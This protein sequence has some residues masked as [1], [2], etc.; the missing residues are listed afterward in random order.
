METMYDLKPK[1]ETFTYGA[2][3]VKDIG[4]EVQYEISRLGL[5]EHYIVLGGAPMDM[6]AKCGVLF[7]A[8]S[9]V[10]KVPSHNVVCWNALIS[11]YAQNR[12]GQQALNPL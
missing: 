9:V 12:Q 11:G 6:Y 4:K 10:E 1:I 2:L 7:Q 5:L 8:Q 3:G